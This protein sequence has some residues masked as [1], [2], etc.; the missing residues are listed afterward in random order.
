MI[1]DF[2]TPSV[3]FRKRA[4]LTQREA[5]RRI[6]VSPVFL[7]DVEKGQSRPGWDTLL[8]MCVIYETNPSEFLKGMMK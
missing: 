3:A 6:G 8:A 7:C 5:A 1:L 4:R 2:T